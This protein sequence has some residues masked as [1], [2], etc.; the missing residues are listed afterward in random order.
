MR[1]FGLGPDVENMAA[2]VLP[3]CRLM[4]RKGSWWLGSLQLTFDIERANGRDVALDAAGNIRV[5]TRRLQAVIGAR[6]AADYG[7]VW[8]RQRR[9]LVGL[10]NEVR[11]TAR[12]GFFCCWQHGSLD[13]GVL[14]QFGEWRAE[15]NLWDADPVSHE[16]WLVGNAISGLWM[17]LTPGEAPPWSGIQVAP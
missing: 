3:R 5:A 17:R 1:K 10:Y 16:A 9:V 8:D 14:H 2:A 15:V 7:S 6:A 4:W 13:S 12:R 11:P